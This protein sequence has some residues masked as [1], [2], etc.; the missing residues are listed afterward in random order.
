MEMLLFAPADV[1]AIGR[2]LS[3][4]LVGTHP[5]VCPPGQFAGLRTPGRGC[6]FFVAGGD[7]ISITYGRVGPARRETEIGVGRRLVVVILAIRIDNGF[8]AAFGED[9]CLE[10]QIALRR[11]RHAFA[12]GGAD[13]AVFTAT[14]KQQ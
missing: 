1:L 10:V 3:L 2:L 12:Q 5:G 6:F 9:E 8:L 11:S 13:T 14:R 4:V 7:Y